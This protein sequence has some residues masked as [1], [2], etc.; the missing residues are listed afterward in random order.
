MSGFLASCAKN[1]D[2]T[3][4]MVRKAGPPEK[5]M[6]SHGY[7]KP[8]NGI[9]MSQHAFRLCQERGEIP[10]NRRKHIASLLERSTPPPPHLPFPS[11]QQDYLAAF[12]MTAPKVRD[13]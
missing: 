2:H 9:L 5:E 12:G 8:S 10:L 11:R 4:K 7:P 6:D 3:T 1:E 13:R